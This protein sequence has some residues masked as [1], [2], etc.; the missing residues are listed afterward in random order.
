MKSFKMVVHLGRKLRELK[1]AV[2][3]ENHQREKITIERE[4]NHE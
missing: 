4:G 3:L 2:W 1:T